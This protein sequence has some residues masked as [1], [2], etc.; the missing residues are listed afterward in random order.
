[1]SF[2]VV[3]VIE[4]IFVMFAILCLGPFKI[5]SVILAMN[6]EIKILLNQLRFYYWIQRLFI[7]TNIIITKFYSLY[8][9]RLSSW[10]AQGTFFR[11]SDCFRSHNRR[12]ACGCK[13]CHFHPK[14]YPCCIFNTFTFN[15]TYCECTNHSTDFSTWASLI[16]WKKV[17][18]SLA[19]TSIR[20]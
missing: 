4:I 18:C 9:L 15:K 8:N 2:I 6:F 19:Q 17:N 7:F 20:S 12:A 14:V 11:G 13:N 1:V 5:P 16:F 10:A 3:V